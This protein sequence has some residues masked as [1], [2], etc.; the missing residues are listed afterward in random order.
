MDSW[1]LR[2][3]SAPLLLRDRQPDACL[4]AGRGD[5]DN[6]FTGC[7][8]AL[9]VDTGKMA[10][11]FQAS[12]HDTHD[13]DSTETPALADMPFNGRQRKLLMMATRNGYFYVLDRVSGEHLVTAKLGLV[14]N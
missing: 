1:F 9:N 2:S 6:L 11:Y 12:P 14:N 7:L 10:R 4:H 5:G 13:W 3:R 8:I